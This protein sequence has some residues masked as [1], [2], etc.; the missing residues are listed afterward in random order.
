MQV[1]NVHNA[2]TFTDTDS[3]SVARFWPLVY[4]HEDSL[5]ITIYGLAENLWVKQH[6]SRQVIKE[7][8]IM[9]EDLAKRA[10]IAKNTRKRIEL[11]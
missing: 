2:A 5:H 11:S 1:L 6:F 10:K 7:R 9:K 8:E 4:A 3:P